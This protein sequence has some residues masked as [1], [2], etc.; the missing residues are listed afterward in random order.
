MNV[1]QTFQTRGLKHATNLRPHTRSKPEALDTLQ[2]WGLRHATNLRPHTRSKSKASNTL[3]TWGLR[4]ATNVRPQ[5]RYKPGASNTLQTRHL[6]HA[7]NLRPQTRGP[8]A[9]LR[10]PYHSICPSHISRS[11]YRM[12]PGTPYDN[13]FFFNLGESEC[14]S[15]QATN[16]Q[17]S[18]LSLDGNV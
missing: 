12:W 7:P 14:S 11:N 2:T 16:A 8:W 13:N 6:K 1:P 5:T 17:R 10:S 4:H 18:L 9:T 15:L 3:Q